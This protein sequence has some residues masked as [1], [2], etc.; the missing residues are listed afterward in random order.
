MKLHKENNIFQPQP[1]LPTV[2][3]EAQDLLNNLNYQLTAAAGG[4]EKLTA[5]Q[6]SGQKVILTAFAIQSVQSSRGQK[7]T[8][9]RQTIQDKGD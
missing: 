2:L 8:Q 6:S 5:N 9:N 1:A 3:P 4:F 7:I